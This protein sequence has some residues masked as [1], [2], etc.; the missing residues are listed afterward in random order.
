VHTSSTVESTV[1]TQ[2]LHWNVPYIHTF[3]TWTCRTYTG[4][5]RTYKRTTVESA[6]RTQGLQWKVPYVHKVYTGF[7]LTY[8]HSTPERVVRTL[9]SA[10]RTQGLHWNVPYVH[11]VYTGT[12]R[13]YTSSKRIFGVWSTPSC[14]VEHFTNYRLYTNW[15]FLQV[16][17]T[18][19]ACLFRTLRLLPR[20]THLKEI[21]WLPMFLMMGIR[22]DALH[23]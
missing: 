17:F 18:F 10:V 21:C 2:G 14:C 1:R 15:C 11:K 8:I 23:M 6:V 22:L 13:T 3:Y 12:C 16:W 4:K 20:S 9:E 7:C 5:C 19:L